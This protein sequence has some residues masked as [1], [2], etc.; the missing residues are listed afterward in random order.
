MLAA[1]IL[2]ALAIEWLRTPARSLWLIGT[3]GRC[4]A[5]AR[6]VSPGRVR[7]GSVSRLALAAKGLDGVAEKG[8]LPPLIL[9]NLAPVGS[10]LRVFAAFTH[11]QQHDYLSTLQI[12]LLG[13]GFSTPSAASR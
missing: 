1:L 5:G 12:E 6:V 4:A 10:F 13:R 7:G 11:K 8:A 9:Y 3:C 2:L